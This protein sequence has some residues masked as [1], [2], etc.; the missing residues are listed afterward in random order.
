MRWKIWGLNMPIY[1]YKCASCGEITERLQKINDT[2]LHDCPAC[3]A[4][5]ALHRLISHTSFILKGTGW[6]ET[7]FKDKS[8]KNV[9]ESCCATGKSKIPPIKQK[10]ES[11]GESASGAETPS[12]DEPS[13]VSQ[14]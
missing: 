10:T 4:K 3:G 7:D 11:S 12:K 5:G 8:K 9:G 2:L 14:A 6:Y 13:K 1:E